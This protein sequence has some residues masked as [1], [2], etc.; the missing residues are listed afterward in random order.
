MLYFCCLNL[1]RLLSALKAARFARVELESLCNLL[2]PFVQTY[3]IGNITS[4][5]REPN[6]LLASLRQLS[7]DTTKAPRCATELVRVSLLTIPDGSDML[8][9]NPLIEHV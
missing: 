8:I 4:E 6:E 9:F 3:E 7:E 2:G 1:L 5:E